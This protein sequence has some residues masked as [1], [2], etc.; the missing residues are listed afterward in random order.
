M[1]RRKHVTLDLK[2]KMQV[3]KDIEAGISY[4]SITSTSGNAKAT[5]ADI[6]KNKIITMAYL[7]ENNLGSST[8]KTLKLFIWFKQE[9]TN[10]KFFYIPTYNHLNF[11]NILICKYIQT[12]EIKR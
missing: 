1:S 7:H 5:V 10:W 12:V 4:S 11:A 6:K 3:I 8:R 9:K 2:Q